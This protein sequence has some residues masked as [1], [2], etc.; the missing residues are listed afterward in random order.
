MNVKLC[1]AATAAAFGA[2]GAQGA[3]T[4]VPA[5]TWSV[6]VQDARAA[7]GQP[8]NE[9]A[10]QLAEFRTR[11]DEYVRLRKKAAKQAPPLKETTDPGEIKTAQEGLASRIRALRPDAQPGDIFVA[12]VR[13]VFRRLL[14]P[15]LKGEEGR[16]VKAV[17]KE[18]APPSVP[19]KVNAKYPETAPL[20]T[21]P[22]NILAALPPL[23]KEV[24]YRLVK[25]DLLLF[26]PEAE[27]IVDY[28]ANAIR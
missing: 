11:V 14:A 27:I 4:H 3:E 10:R 20:P 22:A 9:T 12:E 6:E 7:T 23:P 25:K 5:R 26:D 13:P 8:V 15:K 24:E 1:I 16:D 21:V 17:L 18:D 28:I 2:I 19:L